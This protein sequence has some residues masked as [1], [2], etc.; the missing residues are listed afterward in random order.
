MPDTSVLHVDGIHSSQIDHMGFQL[1]TAYTNAHGGGEW[2]GGW[3]NSHFYKPVVDIDWFGT[4]SIVGT[5]S[6][7]TPSDYV[8][9]VVTDATSPYLER[10]GSSW[11]TNSLRGKYLV[12]VDD[13]GNPTAVGQV[14]RIMWNTATRLYIAG[15]WDWLPSSQA[16]F[17]IDP[18]V[19]GYARWHGYGY[20]SGPNTSSCR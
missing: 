19:Y 9:R 7:P 18:A 14:R 5:P 3:M 1:Q 2:Q 10:L 17:L 8:G 12:I 11:A 15:R 4:G 16:Q 13:P 6:L 20:S